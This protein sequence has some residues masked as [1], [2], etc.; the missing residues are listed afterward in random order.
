MTDALT[1]KRVWE[2][3]LAG[4]RW[5]VKHQEPDGSWKGLR[6]PDVD[7]FYKSSWALASTGQ[8][9]AAQRSLTYVRRQFLT[10]EGDF[11]P[12]KHP[13]HITAHYPYANAYL[14]VGSMHA[15]RY[16][17][18]MPAV[19]FLLSQQS[20]DH[21]GFHSRLTKPGDREVANTVSSSAGGMACLAAG[22]IGA[23]R[24]AADYL[25]HMI[26]LQPS[27][28]DRFFTMTEANGQ[29]I[30]DM[31]QGP[32][33][34]LQMIDTGKAD[35][36]WFTVGLPL[37]F[38]IQLAD[39][40]G[41]SHYLDLA[42]WY[43]HFQRRCVNPWDGWSSGKAGWGCAM[44][45]RMTGHRAYRDIA[46]RTAEFM[47]TKQSADGGWCQCCREPAGSDF[48]LTAEYTLWLSLISANLSARDPGNIPLVTDVI[49]VPKQPFGQRGRRA[50]K[51]HYGIVK[52]EGLRKYFQYSYYYRKGQVLGWIKK[53]FGR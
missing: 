46:L 17:I 14:I 12:R 11:L 7:A 47:M 25:A 15:G 27:P 50:L 38:L 41:E 30:T 36:C 44:L 1:P 39:A 21:G 31:G 45:Y 51:T 33:A 9:A 22:N 26:S 37:A 8:A 52:N 13:W 16:E 29:L 4:S 10:E 3:A 19:S 43:F 34:C 24:C 53:K 35:Q 6:N 5:L 42:Q 18:A 49:K 48:D 32:D 2:H 20:T 40:T 28:N 23:A